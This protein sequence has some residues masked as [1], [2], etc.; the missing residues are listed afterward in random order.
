MTIRFKAY[1]V[2][3]FMSVCMWAGIIKIATIAYYG[4]SPAIDMQETASLH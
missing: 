3:L 4:T 1:S 2:A